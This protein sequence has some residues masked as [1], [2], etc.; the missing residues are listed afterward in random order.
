MKHL[1]TV[2]LGIALAVGSVTASFA[3]TTG[4]FTGASNHITTGG[5]TIVKNDDGTATVTFDSSFSL[6]GAPDPRVGFGKDGAYVDGTDLGVLKKLAGTQSYI[7]PASL[8]ID[9]FNELYIWCLKFAV[10]L[11]VAQLS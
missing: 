10:P 9:D 5:V 6:D 2:T 8:N 4:T 11:G 1:I 3:D 7:V